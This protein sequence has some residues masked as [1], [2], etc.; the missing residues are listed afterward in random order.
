MNTK[1]VSVR[2]RNTGRVSWQLALICHLDFLDTAAIL[3]AAESKLP[4]GSLVY[5]ADAC[6]NVASGVTL[7]FQCGHDPVCVRL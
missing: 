2:F 5:F 1:Q 6:I 7:A 4:H 3:A